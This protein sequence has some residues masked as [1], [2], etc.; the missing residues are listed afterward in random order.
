MRVLLVEDDA[1]KF[2]RILEV[3]LGCGVDRSAVRHVVNASDAVAALIEESFDLLILDVNIPR[4]LGEGT[5]R[6]G[7][8]L[9]LE[10][11]EDDA[12]LHR[13]HYIVGVSA[14]ADA[15]AEFGERFG[16]QLWSVIHYREDVNQW[17][18]QLQELIRHTTAAGASRRFSDGKTYG[19][20]LAIVCA[21]PDVEMAA[22][23]AIAGLD[24]ADLRLPFD[25]TRYLVGTIQTEAGRKS[26]IAATAPRMGMPAAAVLAAKV[27]LQFRPRALAMV[28][29]CA[30]REAKTNIGDVIVADPVW[31]YGSG[32]IEGHPE[33]PRFRPR[34]HQLPLDP[35]LASCVE[36]LSDDAGW[37][38]DL[39]R[40]F[41]GPKPNTELEVRTGPM[42]SGAAVVADKTTFDEIIDRQGDMLAI[43][44]EAYAVFAATRGCGKPRPKCIIA[45]S[46]SDYA[47]ADKGDDF[48]AYAAFTSANVLIELV[49][50]GLL[51]K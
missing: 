39:K 17:A 30:G 27:V 51:D 22:I 15:I 10:E 7:G 6:G 45:K 19:Y 29:I 26:V 14:Y 5:T 47:D 3:V 43:E 44:M 46:V 8:L 4:R 18:R 50:R 35:D 37:L 9:V 20:D 13:P 40:G 34:A 36:E 24:W 1:V 11:I 25:E 49:R 33:G 16:D 2:G 38:A 12:S 41:L 23:R 42:A 21:V 31:D 32:K 28:G 48:Q